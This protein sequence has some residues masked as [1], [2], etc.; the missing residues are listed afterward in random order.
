MVGWHLLSDVAVGETLCEMLIIT[1][2]MSDPQV[3]EKE[4][5][6]ESLQVLPDRCAVIGGRCEFKDCM[7]LGFSLNLFFSSVMFCL[8]FSVL[9]VEDSFCDVDLLLPDQVKSKMF[10]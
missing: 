3:G 5:S 10:A 1:S 6:N 4:R 8:A 7:S 9:T 2:A